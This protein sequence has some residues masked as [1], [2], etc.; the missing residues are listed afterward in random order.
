MKTYRKFSL[1]GAVRGIATA[2]ALS[3]A[4]LAGASVPLTV[5]AVEAAGS[6]AATLQVKAPFDGPATYKAAFEA[7]RDHHITL[8]DPAVRAKFSQEW[9][10]RHANDKALSTEEGTDKAIFEMMWSLGQ[11]FDYYN[12]PAANTAEQERHDAT[13]AGVGMS[14]GQKGLYKAV[15]ALGD[16]PKKEDVEPLFKISDAIPLY[17]PDDPYDDAPAGLG[18][19]K[20][21]D[22]ITAVDGQSVNGKTVEEV[23]KLIR[24]KAGTQ[25]KITVKRHDDATNSDITKDIPLTRA[26]VVLHVVRTKELGDSVGYIRLSDFVSKFATKEMYEALQ[27]EIN[28]NKDKALVIDLRNNPGGDLG[29]VMVMSQMFI[30]SGVL[31][32]Q[33]QR[34]EDDMITITTRVD[35]T[36]AS[37]DIESTNGSKATKSGKRFPLVV[38][39]DMPV[40]VLVN[41]GSASASEILSGALQ[42][43]HRAI[44]IG[45]PSRGKGVGQHVIKLPFDRN[46]HVTSFEFR[47]GGQVMDWVGIVP[48]VEVK[49][50]DDANLVDDPSSDNQLARAKQEAV[51][52]L[53]GKPTAARPQAEVDARKAELKKTHQ[54]DFA[55]EVEA[56]RKAVADAANAK[57]D[58]PDTPDTAKGKPA[59][60]DTPAK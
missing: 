27:K 58:H 48:D 4:L 29:Q 43:N 40:I 60:P 14:L 38:P 12:P 6:P 20:K 5:Q 55:K 59:T 22:I 52:A 46:M 8:Q 36:G 25:V 33:I 16:K 35:F 21:G 7:L 56:R 23:V 51:N 34:D 11:R 17:V 54:D 10:N 50:P 24:G 44:V 31:L 1:G 42:A 26:Q 39:A 9:Q 13:L 18:G 3:L 57:A 15:K 28:T 45:E 30:P 19:I 41:G 49:L 47:P 32:Q 37:A 53:N 2:A